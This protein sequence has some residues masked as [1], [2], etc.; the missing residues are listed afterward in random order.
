MLT[1]EFIEFQKTLAMSLELFKRSSLCLTNLKTTVVNELDHI[2]SLE[3]ICRWKIFE[4]FFP[5][6][7][8]SLF[9]VKITAISFSVLKNIFLR[10]AS[11]QF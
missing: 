4:H 1:Y 11:F 3:R 7:E 5:F 9:V 6:Q 8:G 10:L 2:S